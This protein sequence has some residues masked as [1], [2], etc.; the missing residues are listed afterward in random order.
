MGK[1]STTAQLN[2]AI[3]TA[4]SNLGS[5]FNTMA[6]E[7][8]QMMNGADTPHKIRLEAAAQFQILQDVQAMLD[9]RISDLRPLPA[10]VVAVLN[11]ER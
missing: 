8:K 3:E 9:D 7:A 6:V 2:D 4:I 1:S 5:R 10:D 11:G